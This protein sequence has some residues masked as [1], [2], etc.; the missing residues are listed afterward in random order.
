MC[1]SMKA[2]HNRGFTPHSKAVIMERSEALLTHDNLQPLTV[3]A[4][5]PS[6]QSPEENLL[7]LVS[8]IKAM[9]F[10]VWIILHV[11]TESLRDVEPNGEK[12]KV[13]RMYC[14]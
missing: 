3:T 1:P 10:K 5:K 7:F 6:S 12:K 2:Y 14:R 9:H 11:L 13:F 4:G 8:R